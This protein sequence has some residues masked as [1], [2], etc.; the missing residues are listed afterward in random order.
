MYSLGGIDINSLVLDYGKTGFAPKASVERSVE[1]GFSGYLERAVRAAST[2]SL[3][4]KQQQLMQAARD[5][6]A[7]FVSQVLSAMRKTVPEGEGLFRP[8]MGERIF[9]DMLDSELSGSVAQ[10]GGFG[11]ASILYEQLADS[12]VSQQDRKPHEDLNPDRAR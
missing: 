4:K 12:L 7:I 9:R 8:S 10:A 1:A 3:E 11:L 6:E 2:G 5:F